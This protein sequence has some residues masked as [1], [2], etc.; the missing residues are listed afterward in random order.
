MLTFN[1]QLLI[2]H[3]HFSTENYYAVGSP[4]YAGDLWLIVELPSD[5]RGRRTAEGR[6]SAAHVCSAIQAAQ[7]VG[8]TPLIVGARSPCCR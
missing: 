5:D 3:F 1:L 2:F 6:K 7:T 8:W 4:V